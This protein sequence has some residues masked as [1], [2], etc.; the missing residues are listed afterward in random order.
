MS[1]S[2]PFQHLAGMRSAKVPDDRWDFYPC[3]VDDAPASIFVNFW[4]ERRAP[5]DGA[6][7]LCWILIQML[8]AGDHGMG[9][10]D[11]AQQLGP[12][13][14]A[15][16]EQLKREGI[17]N[18]G[19]LRNHG[20]WQLTF[21]G[22]LDAEDAFRVVAEKRVAG[23]AFEVGSKLDPNWSYY[24][25][26]LL[27]NAE[28]RRWIADHHVIEALEREGDP[29]TKRRRV[30]HW[31]YFPLAEQRDRFIAA[32]KNGGFEMQDGPAPAGPADPP[33]CAM[34]YREESVQLEDIHA[35]VMS[36]H[37]LAEQHGGEY[38]GWE[39][40]VERE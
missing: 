16:V 35:V 2:S 34:I 30:D 40:S 29:L 37:R 28:R 17:F 4:F 11:G 38:D 7:T 13:E 14:D 21:Y 3:T 9:S 18:V 12:I 39:T 23:R 8:D 25:D 19:R 31:I 36:L 27:P 24:H 5:L 33:F 22:P 15:I 10:R 6:D 20:R 26:F 1:N 32:C